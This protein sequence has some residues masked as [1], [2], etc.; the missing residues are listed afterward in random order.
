MSNSIVADDMVVSFNYTLRRASDNEVLDASE[1]EPMFY[2]HG[3]SNI[4]PGLE[5]QLTGRAV[6]DK[7]TANVPAAEA[8]GEKEPGDPQRVP[9]DAFP[10]DMPLVEGMP[11]IAEGPDGEHHHFF[12]VGVDEEDEVVLIDSNHPLAGVDLAFEVEIVALRA[13]TAEELE[14]GHPHGPDGHSHH[15]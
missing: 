13:A 7:L 10:E 6:G 1:D 5:R 15:H 2:L 11:L 14:H 12:I 8:Y 9:M 4:V 3:A